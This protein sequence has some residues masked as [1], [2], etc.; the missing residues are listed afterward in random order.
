MKNDEED[1]TVTDH[2]M[3]INKKLWILAF[4]GVIVYYILIPA[5][6]I[7]CQLYIFSTK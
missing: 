2:V 6:K 3:V 4:I 7:L 5:C 1:K